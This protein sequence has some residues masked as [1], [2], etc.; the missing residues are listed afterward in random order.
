MGAIKISDGPAYGRNIISSVTKAW[1]IAGLVAVLLAAVAGLYASNM[2]TKPVLELINA[3]GQ[4]KDGDLSTRVTFTKN[5]TT[6]EFFTLA[7]SFNEMA[8]RIDVTVST[9]R[10]FVADAAHELHTP[11]TALHT[12]LELAVDEK[13]SLN[14]LHYLEVAQEQS[15]RLESLV[16]GLLDLSRIEASSTIS[17]MEL[18]ISQ[19]VNEVYEIFASRAEMKDINMNVVTPQEPLLV[20]ANDLQ[21]RRLISNLVD[22]ALKFTPA[23]GKTAL[24]VFKKMDQVVI[25]VSDTGI[26]IPSD[27]LPFLFDRFHRGRNASRFQG[28][29]LGLAIVK[30]LVEIQGGSISAESTLDEGTTITVRL[31]LKISD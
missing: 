10:S 8:Q 28:N 9:L 13:N 16:S 20:E 15:L 5:R 11:L 26:G 22:N 29:G 2:V 14:Q 27:D 18:N 21:L 31:P 23:G 30:A 4:M 17:R 12:N 3:T 25:K 6:T 7:E 24:D 1:G 19:I